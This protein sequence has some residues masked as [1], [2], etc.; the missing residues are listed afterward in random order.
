MQ[1]NKSNNQASLINI[2]ELETKVSSLMKK[3][4]VSSSFHNKSTAVIRSLDKYYKY[5]NKFNIYY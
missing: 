3:E 5:N 2:K 4:D 1:I